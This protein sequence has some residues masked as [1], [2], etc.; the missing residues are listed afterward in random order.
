MYSNKFTLSGLTLVAAVVLT[1]CGGGGGDAAPTSAGT[2]GGGQVTP[3]APIAPV[4]S[5][6]SF[7]LRQAITLANA[8]GG[9]FT[10]RANGSVSTEAADG[11]CSGTFTQTDLAATVAAAND[12]NAPLAS[13]ATG[14][15]TYTNCTPNS[16]QSATSYF[17]SNYNIIGYG[18]AGG[19]F[20]VYSVLNIPMAVMV[21]D[22]GVMGTETFYTDSNQTVTK[23]HRDISFSIEADTANSVIVNRIS[24]YYYPNSY[25]AANNLVLGDVLQ[26]TVQTK[27]R[28]TDAG[29]FTTVSIDTQNLT[30]RSSFGTSTQHHFL[31]K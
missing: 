16:T 28:L 22:G 23:G 15:I 4:V 20:R 8:N 13:T 18:A 1:A 14:T 24:K 5:T 10:L 9:T 11:L 26:S 27:Y 31:W 2:S 3:I 21:G 12:Y 25:D 19:A 30:V 7:P 17:D 29:N 6:L